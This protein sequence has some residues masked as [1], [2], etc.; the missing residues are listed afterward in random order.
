MSVDET[1]AIGTRRTAAFFLSPGRVLANRYRVEQLLGRGGMGEVWLAFDLKLRTEVAIKAM[2]R[3]RVDAENPREFLRE[4][5]RN[6]RQ[7]VSPNVCRVFDLFEVDDR[8][9]VSMEYVDGVTLEKMLE[10][11]GPLELQNAQELAAQLLAGIE[12]IHRAGLIH[13]DLKPS[14]IMVTRAGRVV[15]MD[16]GL[17]RVVDGSSASVSGTPPYMAPEQ[18]AGEQIDARADLFSAGVVLGEMVNPEGV[19]T[20]E[21]RRAFWDA[22]R[23]DPPRLPETPWSPLLRK[24]LARAPAERYATAGELLRALEEVTLRIAGA[25]HLN[26]YP[27]LSSFTENDTEYFFGR[28]AEVEQMWRKLQQPH[29]HALIGPSGAGKSSFLRA[30]LI[31]TAPAGWR[32]IVGTPGTRPFISLAQAL[33]PEIRSKD[34]AIDALLRFEEPDVAVAL[35]SGWRRAHDQVLIIL[36]QFEELFTLNPEE[37]QESFAALLSRLALEADAHVLLSLRDDFFFYCHRFE[38]LKPVFSE[39][40]ALG[41]PTGAA[42]RR[43]LVHPALRCGYRFE[44]ESL[45]NEILAEVEG[46]RGALPLMAFAVS[47]VWRKRDRERGLLTREA[48]QEIGGV[49]GALAQHAEA[50]IERIGAERT[51]IVRELFRNLVTAQGTRAAR[52]RNEL[53]SV[54]SE[55][56]R[57]RVGE[58][59]DLLVDARLLT[60]YE[61]KDPS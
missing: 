36:D 45:V 49:A 41:P 37:V 48:Y 57:E 19:R 50:T 42:L 33:L 44:D 23:H 60:S 40:T 26:P 2:L 59:L 1:T 32:V 14:N 10:Q 27:G 43:A 16:F 5:V 9:L 25:E 29:L 17:S 21:A 3:D 46:E 11:R 8:E 39:L 61:L 54:F 35:V 18:L 52:E 58:V 56:E 31:A 22:I 47:Q 55:Q 4:E 6:A 13:R 38:S 28:E 7:V 53:L 12:E 24:A 30:G 51:P 15:V 20:N 34:S